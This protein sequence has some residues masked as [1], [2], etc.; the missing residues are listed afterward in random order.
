MSKLEDIRDQFGDTLGT[1]KFAQDRALV[2]RFAGGSITREDYEIYK[3]NGRVDEIFG[4]IVPKQGFFGLNHSFSYSDA[5][6]LRDYM[7]AADV[8]SFLMEADVSLDLDDPKNE[9]TKEILLE[10]IRAYAL[11][12]DHPPLLLEPYCN[13]PEISAAIEHARHRDVSDGPVYN[14]RTATKDQMDEMSDHGI[15]F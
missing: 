7:L 4:H 8:L 15:G 3:K 10:G 5:E 6:N 13:H 2:K 1:S 11:K 9:R 14:P 12:N